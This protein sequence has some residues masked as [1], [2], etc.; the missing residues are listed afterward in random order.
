MLKNLETY[1]LAFSI[2]VLTKLFFQFEQQ[3][4]LQVLCRLLAQLLLFLLVAHFD[5]DIADMSIYAVEPCDSEN[6][7]Y[8]RFYEMLWFEGFLSSRLCPYSVY[9]N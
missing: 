4:S 7:V 5:I 8:V 1:L 2:V 9:L 6:R 3:V